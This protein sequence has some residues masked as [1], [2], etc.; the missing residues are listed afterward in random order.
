M[1]LR[2]PKRSRSVSGGDEVEMPMGRIG[3]ID[4]GALVIEQE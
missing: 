1:N 4:V 3:A 2:F